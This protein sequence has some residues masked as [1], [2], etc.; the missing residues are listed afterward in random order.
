M[1]KR[2]RRE[3]RYRGPVVENDDEATDI[4]GPQEACVPLEGVEEEAPQLE[5]KKEE[6]GEEEEVVVEKEPVIQKAVKPPKKKFARKRH[7]L[8]LSDLDVIG[9]KRKYTVMRKKGV[10]RGPAKTAMRGSKPVALPVGESEEGENSQ[11]S[12][13][14]TNRTNVIIC[15]LCI[16]LKPPQHFKV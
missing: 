15:G 1:L 3:T 10:K 6:K 14:V 16:N 2:V 12:L 5:A 13:Q 8:K 7:G 4:E 9:R 11:A